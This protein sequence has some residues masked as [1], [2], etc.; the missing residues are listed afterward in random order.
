MFSVMSSSEEQHLKFTHFHLRHHRTL[1]SQSHLLQTTHMDHPLSQL[2]TN[3]TS[4]STQTIYV[5]SMPHHSTETLL[6]KT[7][8]DILLGLDERHAS[9]LTLLDLSSSFDTIDHDNLSNR[10]NYLHGI[11]GT[12]LSW[13]RLYLSNRKQSVAIGDVILSTK[14][15]HH[16]VLQGSVLVPILFVLYIQ[17]LS[18]LIKLH[19]L[20]VHLFADDIQT[21]TF[22]LPQHVH[23]A[24]SSVEICISDVKHWIIENKPQLNDEKTQCRPIHP[25]KLKKKLH[26]EQRH[27]GIANFLL[28][29]P[30]YGIPC[31]QGSD[32]LILSRNLS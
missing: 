30:R 8:N 27:L 9:L 20:S 2:F 13:L 29:P 1:Y 11:S 4:L 28:Q 18:N 17:P 6:L 5:L 31:L 32:I 10:L 24:I 25:N 16:G 12:C 3:V 21:E 22:I 15:L 14:E 23:S 19:S 26:C 7:A